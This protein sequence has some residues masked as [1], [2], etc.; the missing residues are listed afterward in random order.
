MELKKMN[1]TPSKEESSLK[2]FRF[3]DLIEQIKTEFRQIT[4][5]SKEELIGYTKIV[6]GATFVLGLGVYLVDLSIQSVM[7]ILTLLSRLISG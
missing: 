5:T 6:V 2:K 3:R 7:N 4:W 1:M